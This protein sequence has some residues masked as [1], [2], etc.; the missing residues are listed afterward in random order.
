MLVAV[1]A[2]LAPGAAHSAVNCSFNGLWGTPEAGLAQ[3]VLTLTNQH[4]ASIGLAPLASSSTLTASA[5][6][7]S[8]HMAGNDYFDHNDFAF[9]PL[10]SLRSWSTRITD[11]DYPNAG[12]GE[13]IAFGYSSAQAV[14]TGWLN[15]SGHRANIES[16]SYKAIGIGV[17]RDSGGR[18]WWTQNFGSVS[19]GGGSPPPPTGG[20]GDDPPTGGAGDDPPTGGA[21]DDPPTGGAGDDPPTGGAGDD[22]PTGGAGDDPPT[23]GAG[24]DPPTG[25]AGDDPP[26]GGAGDDPPTG[27]AGD[28]PPTGGA[29]DDP[30]TPTGSATGD[31]PASALTPDAGGSLA[32]DDNVVSSS[33]LVVQ[34]YQVRAAKIRAGKKFRARVVVRRK[35]GALAARRL[36]LRCPALLAGD[37][38]LKVLRSSIRGLGHRRV[39]ATC[40]WRIP[41]RAVGKKLEAAVVVGKAR[42]S[43]RIAFAAK[44]RHA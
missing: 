13:N 8:G 26:T 37:R 23:G 28:D 20:A 18:L 31:P 42:D 29:G 36:A 27:G 41:K 44:V 19:D 40:V 22:P 9:A 7:K 17:V 32:S 5:V 33:R 10:T 16:G 4:R 34:G 24:D 38:S 43:A 25:G 21:G 12:R 2:T 1:L 11:C 6:W 14:M 39:Q 35:R 30:V 3:Q 15:S